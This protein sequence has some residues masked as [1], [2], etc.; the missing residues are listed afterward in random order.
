M[1]RF[2]NTAGVYEPRKHYML[3]SDRRLPGLGS[4][5]DKEAY[6]VVHAPRQSGK[7][8]CFHPSA[9]RRSMALATAS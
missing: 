5:I 9:T 2:F 6:F 4:L 7:T 3:P 8:T 1:A